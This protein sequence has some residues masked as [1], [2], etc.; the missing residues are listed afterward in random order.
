MKGF[1]PLSSSVGEADKCSSPSPHRSES[2]PDPNLKS[3]SS[4]K[5]LSVLHLRVDGFLLIDPCESA[6]ACEVSVSW[7][8]WGEESG[9]GS[10]EDKVSGSGSDTGTG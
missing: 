2:E 8:D 6:C 5:T 1:T 4:V 3:L 10:D 9:C 7:C